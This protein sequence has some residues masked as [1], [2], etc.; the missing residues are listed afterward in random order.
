[1]GRRRIIW[2]VIPAIIL[3]A[4][5]AVGIWYMWPYVEGDAEYVRLREVAYGGETPAE[6]TEAGES[7]DGAA[8]DPL[9]TRQVDWDALRAINPDVIGWV[10]VPNSPIDYPVVQ[11]PVDDPEKY[12]H[13]TFEGRVSYPNNEGALYLDSGNI[14][15]GFAS[16]APLLYGHHQLNNSMFSAFSKNYELDNLNAHNQLYIYTPYGSIHVELFAAQPVN[17]STY[18]IRT[19]FADQLDLNAWLDEQLANSTAIAY[20]PGDVSQ[21][22]TFVTC[23]YH[24]W[25]NQRTLTY[26]RTVESTFDPPR[27]EQGLLDDVFGEA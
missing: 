14:D 15:D 10:F 9:M 27:D 7:E 3:V 5:I 8:A 26:G 17:A 23:S 12:L 11:A 2:L 4:A 20:D 16:M 21:L 6:T 19:D 1:M 24:L 22:W 18:R 13:T 25:R